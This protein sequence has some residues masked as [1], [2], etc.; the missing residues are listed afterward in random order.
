[1]VQTKYYEDLP[2]I[3]CQ[4]LNEIE[5]DLAREA[6][7]F[8]LSALLDGAMFRQAKA[9]LD[10]KKED[11]FIRKYFSL[12][13]DYLNTISLIRAQNLHWELSQLRLV[14]VDCGEIPR[15]VF[16]ESLDVPPEQL[17]AV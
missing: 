2:P 3:Y 1:M 9:V 11:G 10:R 4:T 6:D 7:P 14:L 5:G 13:A 17:G 12:W 8:R 16:E 15:T